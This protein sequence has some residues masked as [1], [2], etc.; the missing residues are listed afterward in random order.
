MNRTVL[1]IRNLVLGDGNVKIC[2]PLTSCNERELEADLDALASSGYDLVEFRADHYAGDDISA[3]KKIRSAIGDKPV[4]YTIRTKEEGGEAQIS[5][6]DYAG[7]NLA[8]APFADLVDVQLEILKRM[9]FD[10]DGVSE[11]VRSL[12]GLGAKTVGSWHD[13]TATPPRS[14]LIEKM[15]AMQRAGCSVSKTA[16]MPR[17]RADVLELL[18]ASVE[19]LEEKADRPFIT[20]S[21]GELGRFTRVAGSFTGSCITFGTAGNL[22]APGQISA[23]LLRTFLDA[24][25]M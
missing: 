1:K 6:R 24:L 19:M 20:M 17:R 25:D 12:H 5:D 11:L 14:V 8:A 23:P 21:M 9:P 13:F 10:G 16:V 2:V 15:T 3:L 7:R 22:S 4:L 18:A